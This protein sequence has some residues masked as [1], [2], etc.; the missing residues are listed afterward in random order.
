MMILTNVLESASH[1]LIL[2]VLSVAIST[3]ILLL[4][5]HRVRK[6]NSFVTFGFYISV[7]TVAQFI[8]WES[9]QGGTYTA[10]TISILLACIIPWVGKN[11]NSVGR[12]NFIFVVQAAVS[13]FL[14]VAWASLSASNN[15]IEYSFSI[16][17]VILV[18]FAMLLLIAQSYELIDVICRTI[19]T[20]RVSVTRVD[21]YTPKVS[22]HVPAYNEPP[23]M[24][25]D[26]LNALAKIDYPNYEVIMIDDNTEDET[27]WRPLEAHC[28]KLGFK[29]FHLENW[30]GY[31]SGALNYAITQTDSDAEII[32]VVDAD[33]IVEP[34][35]LK[36][37][38]GEF[39]NSQMA[40]V[41]TPQDY[42]EFDSHDRYLKALYNA[43][44]YFFKLSM[45]SR[46][47]RNSIIFTGTMGL[48]RK[49][50]LLEVGGWD[51]WCITEDAEIAIKI[52]DKGYESLFIDKTYGRGLMPLDFEGLKKQRFRWAFGGMQVLRLH[53]KKL[54]PLRSKS[55]NGDGKLSLQQKIDIWSGGLQWLNDPISLFFTVFLFAHASLFLFSENDSLVTVAGAGL[56][57]PF[58]F[59]FTN[60]MRTLW[61]LKLRLKCRFSEALD[62]L[63]MLLS[64]TWVVSKACILG[65]IQKNGVFL[66]TPKNKSDFGLLRVIQIVDR[67]IMLVTVCIMFI[68]SIILSTNTSVSGYVIGGLLV[69][70]CF[71][72]LSAVIASYWS[73]LSNNRKSVSIDAK[74]EVVFEGE[75]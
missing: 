48:I 70:Q 29:F 52:L 18:F 51:E 47:E 53:W 23:D 63:M 27:L 49:D 69:W 31:K 73:Y 46:N 37:L 58:V 75:S 28:K 1:F 42:R 24:V 71:I 21:G 74:P 54:L 26:T 8:L 41:Q 17:T 5:G 36:D 25:I 4:I 45:A 20:R 22:F 3:S 14:Y 16:L 7:A 39:Q 64:L 2:T 61:G 68:V 13:F 19:W 12:V 40:F 6:R 65:L 43:Y 50:V 59:I 67:E 60:L 35:Y 9:G 11:W 44:Q 10:F 38:V 15:W 57:V 62:T 72:Y 66:R 34:D 55:K 56:F 32:A 30:P 33:Y